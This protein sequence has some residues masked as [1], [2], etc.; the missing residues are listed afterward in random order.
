MDEKEVKDGAPAGEGG[1]PKSGRPPRRRPPRTRSRRPGQGARPA[2][3][4]EAIPEENGSDT[5]AP[6]T[7]ERAERRE[8]ASR[9]GSGRRRDNARSRNGR[10]R[11]DRRPREDRQAR[12]EEQLEEALLEEETLEA[13]VLPE[14]DAEPE[15]ET[16]PAVPERSPYDGPMVEIVG[17]RFRQ[18]GKVYYF[19]PGEFRIEPHSH[20]I[21][22]TA[23]GVEYGTVMI[24]NSEVPAVEIVPPLRAVIRPATEEDE[25]HHTENS[26]REI[27]AYNVCLDKISQYRLEMKLIDAEYT[28]DNN[29]LLFYFTADGRIDF[30][31]LAKDLASVFR[32]R[33]ELR[34]IGIRDEAKMMGGL[35]ICGRPFCCHSFLGDFVQVSIKMA[36]EQNLSLNSA[37]ISGACGRLM[38]CLRYE[39]D[40]YSEEIRKTPKVDTVV[41]TPDGEG[42][43]TEIMPLAGLCKVRLSRLPDEPPK[44]Y[45]RDLLRVRAPK[46]KAPA[47]QTPPEKEKPAQEEA[48]PDANAEE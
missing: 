44:V 25:Q 18:S 37:K 23:R 19:S 38:C 20:V 28:F 9:G 8:D 41:D 10:N 27:E 15:A 17:V 46:V 1:A 7:E 39:Y 2:G 35:G 26:L 36:K 45:H 40:V 6:E 3:S 48:L 30:R 32:T 47:A 21:V 4:G 22:E 33:I 31:E 24:G 29:K 14:P 43:V 42:V 12:V 34:Q 16:P 11:R 5:S 13:D